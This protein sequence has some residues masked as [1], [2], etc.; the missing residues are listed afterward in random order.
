M[1][2][3]SPEPPTPAPEATPAFSPNGDP[4]VPGTIQQLWLERMVSGVALRG[5][6]IGMAI[7]DTGVDADMAGSGRP[8]SAYY[9]GGNP[10]MT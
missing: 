1:P 3:T 9:P 4:Y 10:S 6:G 5:D 8:H 7:L 2:E